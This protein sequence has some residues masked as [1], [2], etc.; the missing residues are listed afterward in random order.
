MRMR[1]AILAGITVVTSGLAQT[2]SAPEPVRLWV[3]QLSGME[4]N[5]TLDLPPGSSLPHWGCF[6]MLTLNNRVIN[7][8]NEC[9]ILGMNT[10]SHNE[11][12]T[13]DFMLW[14]HNYSQGDNYLYD[15]KLAYMGNGG[16]LTGNV[17]SALYSAVTQSD[18]AV[19]RGVVDAWD[20]ATGAL[21]Y[22]SGAKADTLASGRPLINMNPAKWISVTNAYAMP[23][24]G[25][26]LGWG[27]TVCAANAAWTP[28]V[29]GR[30]LAI[31]E[32]GETVPG[33]DNVRRWFLITACNTDSNGIRRLSFQRHWWGAKDGQSIGRLY[34]SVHYTVNEANPR[35][36]RAIIAPGVN[37]Y[38]VSEAVQSPHVNSGG[39]AR[40]LLLAP[41]PFAGSAVDFAP[42]DPVEQAMGPD[43]FRPI[44]FRSW[45]WDAVPGL[46]PSPVFDIA[47]QGVSRQAVLTVGGGSGSAALDR[48]GRYD[49]AVPWNALFSLEAASKYGL[50]FKGDTAR[51]AL[52]FAQPNLTNGFPQVLRWEGPRSRTLGVDRSGTL[53]VSG[54]TPL[55]LAGG[56]LR[57][58]GGLS[59]AGTRP[60]NLRG[61]KA[62]IEP[63]ASRMAIVFPIMEQDA[64][65]AVTVRPSWFA[66]CAVTEQTE[67]G[68]T[69][70]FD[71]PAGKNAVLDWA[72]VR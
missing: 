68:F 25:A 70:T 8:S 52:L 41:S 65:Y 28:D 11:N 10:W 19:F 36:L 39:C 32:P 40:R 45:L 60:A 5:R 16:S 1:H 67:R 48:A 33:G 13:F 30:Y 57:A 9:G 35:L 22:R 43:P 15:A 2:P 7:G 14:R 62:A 23:P 47:N 71:T 51:A 12:Q 17:N 53:A 29:I 61:L 21:T 38:D 66:D 20:P 59:G 37:V 58:P 49:R 54:N 46:F 26:I 64:G 44:P 4:I 50:V 24:G 18:P 3:P 56:A 72:V 63:G 42:G 69:V 27:G 55:S 31:D 34:K 6:P